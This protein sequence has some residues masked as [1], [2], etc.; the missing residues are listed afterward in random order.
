MFEKVG[1]VVLPKFAYAT[2]G[3]NGINITKA[4]C[5]VRWT[6]LTQLQKNLHYI[7]ECRP[8]SST[9]KITEILPGFFSDNDRYCVESISAGVLK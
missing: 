1:V 3:K 6:D 9:E 4:N 7:F 8:A 5:F 2:M